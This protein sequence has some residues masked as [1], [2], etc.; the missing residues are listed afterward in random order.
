MQSWMPASPL[1]QPGPK[2]DPSDILFF[3]HVRWAAHTG[4]VPENA[5]RFSF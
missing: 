3:S 4:C 2:D 5:S 1:T